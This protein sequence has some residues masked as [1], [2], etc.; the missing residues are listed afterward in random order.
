MVR[1]LYFLQA[2]EGEMAKDAK[3]KIQLT[4]GREIWRQVKVEYREVGTGRW[5]SAEEVEHLYP[6]GW[7]LDSPELIKQNL[8]P[9]QLRQQ[10]VDV[11]AQIAL[12]ANRGSKSTSAAR[13]VLKALENMENENLDELPTPWFILGRKL[14]EEVLLFIEQPSDQSPG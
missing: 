14:A 2:K 4:D 11:Q 10:I 13:L 9:D 6:T 3:A 12:D 5:V 8:H 7:E 1:G